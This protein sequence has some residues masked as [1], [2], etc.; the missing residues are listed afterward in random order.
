MGTDVV[1]TTE[2]SYILDVYLYCKDKLSSEA[3]LQPGD[4][5]MKNG[6]LGIVPVL[7]HHTTLQAIST[8]QLNLPHN[9]RDSDNVKTVEMMFFE[10]LK[11]FDN[12]KG[13]KVLDPIEDMEIEFD[14]EQ[15]D[16]DIKELVDAKDK[17]VEELHKEEY[18]KV[19]KAQESLFT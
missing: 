6:R 1:S 15:D 11:R 10:L 5:K 4:P 19:S 9:H 8:I 2:S 14:E 7:L 13:L 16:I 3:F 17:V 12:G 18:K